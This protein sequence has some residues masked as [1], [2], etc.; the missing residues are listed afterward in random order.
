MKGDKCSRICHV[1][2]LLIGSPVAVW[3]VFLK[4]ERVT[5]Y[6][7]R[8][9]GEFLRWRSRRSLLDKPRNKT[10]THNLL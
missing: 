3:L 9:T 5:K 1:M 6:R 10:I 2:P 4:N 7:L 8:E